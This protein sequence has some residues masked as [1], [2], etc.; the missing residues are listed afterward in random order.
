MCGMRE[1]TAV[2]VRLG[3]TRLVDIVGGRRT[4][5]AAGTIRQVKRTADE[6]FQLVFRLML[7]ILYDPGGVMGA[8][9]V[10]YGHGWY[11][12]SPRAVTSSW[13]LLL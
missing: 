11:C 1:I 3:G 13:W 9:H 10:C 4:S 5:W 6:A 2:W 12:L 7:Y 8:S